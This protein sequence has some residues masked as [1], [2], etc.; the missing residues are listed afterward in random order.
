MKNL[1]HI[2]LRNNQISDL[3]ALKE[4]KNLTH[5]YLSENQISDLSALKELKNLTKIYLNSNQIKKLPEYILNLNLDIHY[6]EGSCKGINLY[7]NPL[8]NPSIEIIKQG[9]AT[10]KSYFESLKGEQ[11]PLNEVKVLLVGYGGAGKTSLVKKIFNENI[12]GNESKTN[13]IKIRD[14]NIQTG[15]KD[16][17]LHFWDF[18]GQEIMHSTHQFF[19]SKRSLY[20]LVLDNRKEDNEEYWLKLI[21]SFGGNSPILIALNK[22]DENPS[23]DVNRK[24]LLEKYKGVKDFIRISCKDGKGINEFNEKLKKHLLNVE[25]LETTWAKSW[26]NV[27]EKLQDMTNHYISYENYK[28][29]CE[30]ENVKK[31]E[32][33]KTLVTF[34]NDLGVIVYF[35]DL[36]LCDTNV[37]NPEWVTNAVYKIINSK[38]LAENKGV[39][40]INSL[41]D[42]LTEEDCPREKQQ[43]VVNLM[44]NLNYVTKS[45]NILFFCLIF[46]INKNPNLILLMMML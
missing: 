37:L 45:T 46:W 12:D 31:Q 9:N 35:S 41:S 16:V 42:I 33:Q 14:L 7:D 5:I 8:E 13:G 43:Y 40:D 15:D 17:L 23:F 24:F 20:I 27:K 10:I 19:L 29:I 22:M 2:Y 36:E 18:G 32:H 28:N 34:L 39:L 30:N 44:K 21:E 1:T 26:F 6:K 3:S 4:L 25:I 11:K 38:Q